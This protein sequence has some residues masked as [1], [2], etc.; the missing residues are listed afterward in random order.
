MRGEAHHTPTFNFT[1]PPPLSLYIHFPWCT[2]KCP[3]C[4]FNSHT[5]AGELP[6]AAYIDAL[7]DDLAG[8]LP[9]IWGRTIQ[10]IFIG[11]G[12]PSL[13][14]PNG[15]ERLLSE[16]RALLPLRGD[17]EITLEANPGSVER[18]RFTEFRSAGVNRLSIGIQ[19]FNDARLHSLGRIHDRHDALAAIDAVRHAGFDNFNLDLMFGLPGQDIAGARDDLA[20]ALEFAPSHIS[21]YQLTLEPNTPFHH[22]PPALP[23][24]ETVWEISRQGESLLAEA[25]FDR[26]EV[27]AYAHGGQHCRHNLNYWHFGDYLG[28]GAG[29]HSKITLSAQQRIER[30]IKRRGPIDY[31]NARDG[32]YTSERRSPDPHEVAFEFMLNALRLHKGFA[33]RLFEERAGLPVITLRETLTRACEQGLLNRDATHIRPTERGYDFLNDLIA[34][35]LPETQSI[36]RQATVKANSE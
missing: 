12:T 20:T 28:I 10:S 35:F 31:L 22:Q 18:G 7:L 9:S 36:N 32:G 29:A 1:A 25:G 2:R 26:Y 13:I 17:C 15:L 19:S 23:E 6:E 21:W 4:D 14:S 24:D 34:L 30:V 27:S 16:V 3:Y 5:V 33:I 8:E 11:G